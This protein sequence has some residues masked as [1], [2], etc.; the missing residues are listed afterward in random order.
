MKRLMNFVV[1]TTLAIVFSGCATT[2]INYNKK[3]KEFTLTNNGKKSI[4]TKIELD[5]STNKNYVIQKKGNEEVTRYY[6]KTSLCKKI[7]V[8]EALPLGMNRY[9]LSNAY[10]DLKDRY[11]V[12]VVKRDRFAIVHLPHKLIIGFDGSHNAHGPS[13]K[14]FI[15]MSPKC[16]NTFKDSIDV[17]YENG[18]DS[19]GIHKYTGTKYDKDGYDKNGYLESGF[20]KDGYTR[21]G[22]DRQYFNRKG[23]HFDGSHKITGTI[24]NENGYSENGFNING[25][26]KDTQ[27]KFNS[28]GY[29]VDGYMKDGFNNNAI[30]KTTGTKYDEN[31]YD[32]DGYD[33]NNFNKKGIHYITGTKYDENGKDINSNKK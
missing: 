21:E 23:F 5:Y 19:Y 12:N 25:L 18:F 2:G 11:K 8:F 6:S 31:G 22:Y 20:G 30:N 7:T 28:N 1:A 27:T 32:L 33:I 3:L 10:H 14:T 24:Y 15:E 29:D 9:Y 17:S 16:W 13:S 26:H 4:F